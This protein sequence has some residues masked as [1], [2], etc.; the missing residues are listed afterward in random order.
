[1]EKEMIKEV[2]NDL[3]RINNDRID[4]YQK[5]IGETSENDAD[6]KAAFTDFR[7]SS[8]KNKTALLQLAGQIGVE[9]TTD[10]TAAGK[11]YRMWMDMKAMLSGDTREAILDSCEFGEDAALKLY[12]KVL[13]DYPQM[14]TEMSQ[15]VMAQK[16][17]IKENHDRVKKMRDLARAH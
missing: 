12:D 11:V 2:L 1:M 13:D 10:T 7:V 15:M 17:I 8:E 5:A 3:V 9:T 16:A 4:G 6:L 14:P